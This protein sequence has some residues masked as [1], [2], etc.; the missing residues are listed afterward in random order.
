MV[1]GLRSKQRPWKLAYTFIY[2]GRSVS[3]YERFVTKT[4]AEQHFTVRRRYHARLLQPIVQ[5]YL[6]GPDGFQK[7]LLPVVLAKAWSLSRL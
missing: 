1:W 5:A 4:Q 7:D 3:I 6:N 2:Q